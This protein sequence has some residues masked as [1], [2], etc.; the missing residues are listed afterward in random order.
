VLNDGAR[1]L[2]Q[3]EL[4]QPEELLE[5]EGR[6][7]EVVALPH[8]ETHLFIATG[9]YCEEAVT[10]LQLVW[11]DEQRRWPWERGHGGGRGGQPVLGPRARQVKV[12]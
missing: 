10:A 11:A 7:L 12:P 5:V 1:L 4:P 3:R 2:H 9:L 8:P 6:A